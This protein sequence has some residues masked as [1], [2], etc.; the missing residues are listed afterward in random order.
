VVSGLEHRGAR[1]KE[2]CVAQLVFEE[3]LSLQARAIGDTEANA[4]QPYS[5]FD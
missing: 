2:I 4:D 5:L 1:V 3:H